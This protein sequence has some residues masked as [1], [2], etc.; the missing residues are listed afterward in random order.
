MGVAKCCQQVSIPGPY[1]INVISIEQ[2]SHTRLSPFPQRSRSGMDTYRMEDQT[3]EV[4][5]PVCAS[6]ALKSFRK[7]LPTVD[8][9]R[10]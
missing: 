4:P 10:S 5:L 2:L 3:R 1:F 7:I 6:A 8:L 9:G